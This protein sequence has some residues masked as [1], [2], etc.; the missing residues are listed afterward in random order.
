M[1]RPASLHC[2]LKGSRT[3]VGDVAGGDGGGGDGGGLASP[4]PPPPPEGGVA[5]HV[6]AELPDR[7]Q[8]S[9]VKSGQLLSQQMAQLVM[10][11]LMCDVHVA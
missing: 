5:G 1:K 8:S 6:S 3:Y 10:T 9:H 7:W 11:P 2:V 4:P